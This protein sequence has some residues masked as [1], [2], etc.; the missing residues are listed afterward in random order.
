M[1]QKEEKEKDEV[2]DKHSDSLIEELQKDLVKIRGEGDTRRRVIL[3]SV[4]ASEF[5][6]KA[7]EW[8]SKNTLHS[9]DVIL[10]MTVWEELIDLSGIE[11]TTVDPIGMV[12]VENE[13]IQKHNEEHLNQAKKL[14]V[15]L[16]NAYLVKMKVL[17]LLISSADQGK[18]YIGKLICGAAKALEVDL[19]VMGS[20]GL[21]KVKQFFVGSVSKY[22]VENSQCP[23][24][25]VKT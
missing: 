10:L 19:I 6:V 11:N 17:P 12:I 14:L 20:R 18:S 9:T 25:V 4:D 15:S 16:Y 13:E 7:V 23:V 2:G 22:V 5:S 3:L 24:L 1:T 21:G 8:A